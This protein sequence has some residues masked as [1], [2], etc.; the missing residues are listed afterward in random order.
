MNEGTLDSTS[1]NK[2]VL[3]SVFCNEWIHL[4]FGIHKSSLI[5]LY[6][7]RGRRSKFKKKKKPFS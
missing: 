3:D 6:I 7:N 5:Q 1:H 4:E 2:A